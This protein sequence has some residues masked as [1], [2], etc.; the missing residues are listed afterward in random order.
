MYHDGDIY[1][2]A[3]SAARISYYAISG[4]PTAKFDGVES[5]VGGSSSSSM[6]STYVPIVTTRNGIACDFTVE[7]Y[8]ESTGSTYD[9]ILKL[10][11]VA[12]STASNLKA[13]FVVTESGFP[14]SWGIATEANHVCRQMVPDANGTSIDFTSNPE[15]LLSLQYTMDPTWVA[16]NCELVAFIQDDVTKEV[17]NAGKVPLLQLQPF[18]ATAGFSA[19]NTTT[20]EGSSVSFIDNS[21]GNIISWEWNFEGGNPASS[22]QQNPSVTYAANGDYD[23]QQI[24]YDGAVYDTLTEVNYIDVEAVPVT[25]NTPSGSP[26][27][28]EDGSYDYTTDPVTYASTYNWMV[29]PSDAGTMSGNGTTGTFAAASGWTGAYTIKVR[30]E[31]DCGNSSYSS[32]FAGTLYHTPVAYFLEGGGG[33]CEGDPGKELTLANSEVGVDYELYYEGTATGN[34]M[35]GTGAVLS[36]G[37]V[38]DEGL[39]TAVGYTATCDNNMMGTPWVYVME[40]P[41]QAGLPD[42]PIEV[43]NDGGTT[44]YTT[45]GAIEATTYNWYISPVEAGTIAGSDEEG[46]VTWDP[47]F[48]GNAYISVEGVN[49]CGV[50]PVSAELTVE[51]FELPDPVVAG[52]ELVC[53][54]EVVDYNTTENAGSDYSWDV[55]GGT[56]IEGAGTYMITVQ[57]GDPGTGY[58]S[59]TETNSDNCSE[60]STEMEVTIDDCTGIDELVKDQLKVYPNPSSD[61]TNVEMRLD[62][63]TNIQIYLMNQLGQVVIQVEEKRSEGLHVIPVPTENIPDGLYTLQIFTNGNLKTQSKFIKTK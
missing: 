31:N 49:D 60:T 22:T 48:I 32:T 33:Y 29:E 28:C 12:T 2:N 9:I 35:A 1:A 30:A 27:A 19:S 42:G 40:D 10:N 11:E 23:V 43:C 62:Q 14:V 55:T 18:T 39:Y 37:F 52:L 36:F 56:I 47:A 16:S 45:E 63:Q 61:N 44:S 13:H 46:V 8:G 57:W 15:I 59:V 25:P 51:T 38:T 7:I 34:I 24:V 26:E 17:M 54:D 53:N 5:V 4:F 58:V 50:G 20:C 3:Y 41:L 21:M 6:Y